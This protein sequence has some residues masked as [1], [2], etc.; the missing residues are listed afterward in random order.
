M[1]NYY[2]NIIIIISIGFFI[3]GCGSNDK[4]NNTTITP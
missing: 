1:K 4:S 2:N 3:F